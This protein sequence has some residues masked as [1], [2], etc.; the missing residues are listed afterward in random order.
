MINNIKAWFIK[1]NPIFTSHLQRIGLLRIIPPALA[2][3]I[4]IPVYIFFHI[5]CIKLLYNLLICPLLSVERI[6]LKHYIVI[7]RHLLP[8]LSYTAKFHCAYCG[9]ANGLSVATSVLLTRISTE[10]R[11]PANNILRVL[12]IFAYFITSGLSVLAQSL[13]ILS[14]DY[15][16]A[17]LL[18][19][20]RMSM[21]QATDKMKASGFAGEFTVF[22]KLGRQLLRF[23]Y[24]CSL[25]HANS[26]EQIESQWCP[27]KHL[28][29]YPGAVYP[30]HHEFFIERCEL[31]KLRRV[32]CS[33]GTVSTRK[34]TW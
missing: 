1:R 26:L 20:H 22:G 2:M 16:M 17:P 9:Y 10:A 27:I 4:M 12:L 31:C 25:R 18:G 13:V 6:E 19:L 30:E 21:Q 24:N 7:D 14:F 32:L 28:D 33:E 3:Y 15:V 34:P 11:L 23:E 8:G 5:V 29:D